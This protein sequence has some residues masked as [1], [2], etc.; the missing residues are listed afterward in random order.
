MNN[1]LLK[2]IA[3]FA[4]FFAFTGSSYASGFSGFKY[5]INQP[6]RDGNLPIHVAAGEGNVA[7]LR[8]LLAVPDIDV[9]RRHRY[10]KTALHL[11][12]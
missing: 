6:N 9:N 5:H 4:L 11:P 10:G 1:S 2:T 8:V 12:H 7:D 3:F